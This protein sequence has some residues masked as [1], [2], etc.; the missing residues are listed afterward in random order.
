M[1]SEIR[2]S[3][4]DLEAGL[5]H[6]RRSPKDE[7]VVEMIVRR[8]QTDQREELIEGQLT[9]GEGLVGDNWRQRGSNGSP[10]ANTQ[11]TIMNARVAALVAGERQRWA[12]AG[13]QLFIDLDLS[14][15]NLP[16]GTRLVLGSAVIEI[17]E[18][19]HTGCS[20]FASRFGLEALKFINSPV[21]KELQMRGIYARVVQPGVVQR[22]DLV[23]KAPGSE[24]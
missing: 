24:R 11:L 3:K 21:G 20:K 2:L 15:S 22:G 8:P 9:M 10:P 19:P 13:D 6:I 16:A 7:G 18:K 23:R 1:Q 5:D 4:E 14:K 17:T 12:L